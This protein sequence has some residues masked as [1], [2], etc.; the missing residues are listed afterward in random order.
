MILAIC[1]SQGRGVAK[2]LLYL[3]TIDTALR[4]PHIFGESLL[5]QEGAGGRGEKGSRPTLKCQDHRTLRG[6]RIR[7]L[8]LASQ[9]Y[10]KVYLLRE[11]GK[12]NCI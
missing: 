7:N 12:T 1:T 2:G 3:G 11:E 5:V 6:M 10:I 8:Y 4:Y 9:I